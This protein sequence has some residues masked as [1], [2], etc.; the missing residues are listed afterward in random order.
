MRDYGKPVG[1]W[2]P[3]CKQEVLRLRAHPSPLV[4]QFCH[5][6]CVPEDCLP[7]Y[8]EIPEGMRPE[9]EE[10]DDDTVCARVL[11]GDGGA[12]HQDF[13][14]G[15]DAD[16]EGRH[17]TNWARHWQCWDV[18]DVLWPC[19]KV[20]TMAEAVLWIAEGRLP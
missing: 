17:A 7:I 19:G 9:A 18:A 13:V 20:N 6:S 2:C 8:A 16:M 11:G 1:W 10:P 5:T 15:A 4:A 14:L 3:G 12:T